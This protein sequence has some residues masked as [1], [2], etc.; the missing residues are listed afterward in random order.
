MDG[1][2]IN[3]VSEHE[4]KE[5][6]IYGWVYNKTHKGKLYFLMVRDGTGMIQSVVFKGDVDEATFENAEKLTQESSIIVT[7]KIKEEK[8]APGGYELQ[9]TKLE[10]IQVAEE[11]PITPKEHGDSFLMDHRHLWL[12][13]TR[14]HAI[15]RVRHEIIKASRDFFDQRDFVLVDTPIF[16]PSACEGTTTLFETDYFGKKAYLTQSGQL[17]AEAG[18]MSFGKVYTCSPAFRAEKSKT[19]RHLIEFWLIEPEVAFNDL[20]DNMK[21]AE[22]HVSYVVQRVLENRKEELEVLERDTTILENSVPPYPRIHYD[23]AVKMLNDMGIDFKWGSDFGAPDETALTEKFDKPFF[24]TH[25]PAEIKAFYMK[26]DKDRPECALACDM[27]A[28]EGYGEII[29]GSQREDELDELLS[30]IAEHKLPQEAFEWF[31]DLRRYGTVPHSGYGLG[32]ERLLAW[33]C[34]LPHVR[35]TLPFPRMLHR[36]TP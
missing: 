30:R 12:R 31:L 21:L 34:K 1:V 7:G 24:I 4:G 26:R 13:S 28:P 16:T 23:N 14:Q 22:D 10:I 35:E 8:R 17:Y 32:I 15:L 19:R 33:I 2:Y 25:F 9:V 11:Y 5:V 20:E 27:L 18:A 36:L 29:G 3:K 6:K